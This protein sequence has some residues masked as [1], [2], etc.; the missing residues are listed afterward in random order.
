MHQNISNNHREYVAVVGDIS[1]Q[2][3]TMLDSDPFHRV[4]TKTMASP[5]RYGGVLLNITRSGSGF[6]SH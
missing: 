6:T 1:I 5:E 2:S 3:A 4:E